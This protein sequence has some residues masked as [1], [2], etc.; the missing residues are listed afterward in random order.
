MPEPCVSADFLFSCVLVMIS[1]ANQVVG[2]SDVCIQR[3]NVVK[4][5]GEDTGML[6]ST[7]GF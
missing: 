4:L 3:A 1:L 5:I 2:N 7:V 6:K